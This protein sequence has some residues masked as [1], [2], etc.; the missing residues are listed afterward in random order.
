MHS[1]MPVNALEPLVRAL[2]SQLPEDPSTAII[3][4]KPDSV[5][6]IAANSQNPTLEGPI[7]DPSIV[8]LLELCTVLALRDHETIKMLGEDVSSA[9]QNVIRDPA[10]YHSTMISRSVFYLLSLLRAS[11]VSNARPRPSM[12]D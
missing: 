2:L 4:V 11:Y 7:Y 6:P 3:T 5:T 9:L 10:N 8:Y 1:N 12:R